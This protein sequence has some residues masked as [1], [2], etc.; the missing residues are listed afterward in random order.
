MDGAAAHAG[1]VSKTIKMLLTMSRRCAPS[2]YAR[3]PVLRETTKMLP[4]TSRCFKRGS[5]Q[6]ASI[7]RLRALAMQAANLYLRSGQRVSP[8][9]KLSLT[10]LGACY[11][12]VIHRPPALPFLVPLRLSIKGSRLHAR[13]NM[14]Y[15]LCACRRAVY[16][17]T[18][19]LYVACLM[20]RA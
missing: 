1:L 3:P 12:A 6:R 14:D 20:L 5:G 17:Y 18:Y 9:C 10:H 11:H 7:S 8:P 16:A 13:Q 19:I 2:H 15:V 4:R